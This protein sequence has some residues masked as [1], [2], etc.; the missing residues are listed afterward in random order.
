MYSRAG[1]G[2]YADIVGS[3]YRVQRLFEHSRLLPAPKGSALR[4]V[5]GITPGIRLLWPLL[6]SAQSHQRFLLD[7]LCPFLSPAAY[8]ARIDQQLVDT[9]RLVRPVA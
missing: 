7:A 8:F 2:Q 1:Y 6:T 3:P 4:H 5:P 9:P